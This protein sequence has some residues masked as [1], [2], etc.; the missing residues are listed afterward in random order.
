MKKF[1]TLTLIALSAASLSGQNFGAASAIQTLPK[2]RVLDYD[3]VL[4]VVE[5]TTITRSDLMRAVA[6]F[7]EKLR[8]TSRTEDEFKR[9]VEKL[10]REIL[11]D[12]IDRVILVKEFHDRGMMIPESALES[13]FDDDLK[14]RFNG[15]RSEFLKYLQSQNMT[16]KQYRKEQE[17]NVIVT[18]MQNQQRLTASE[19]SPQRIIEYYNAHK[20]QWYTPEMV[21][22]SQI[23]IKGA[24]PDEAQELAK[25][26]HGEILAGMAFE[27]AAK[28][29][30]QDETSSK[31]GDWGWYKKGELNPILDKKIFE[32]PKGEISEPVL[33]SNYAYILR[34]DDKKSEGIQPLDDVR[35][36]IEWT[37]AEENAKIEYEK[38]IRRLREKAYIKT[39]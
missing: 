16:I 23:T 15:D 37:L 20:Q 13:I 21:K 5:D 30:S 24:T 22:I 7:V 29:Y 34:V 36:K 38:W 26:V 17:E 11:Q 27:D 28:K 3:E 39:F 4:A 31:G 2:S 9:Q 32:M 18:H 35:E 1:F 25:R 6:P 10:W 12:K 19:I 8:K 14:K 33:I